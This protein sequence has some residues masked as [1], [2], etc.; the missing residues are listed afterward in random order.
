[1]SFICY[2]GAFL[3]QS[4]PGLVASNRGY[5]WGDGVFETLKVYKGNI[6]LGSFH[7]ERLL[8]SVQL[9]QMEITYTTQQLTA[10]ILELCKKNGCLNL[11]RVRLTIYREEGN[12]T[13]YTI[14]AIA[15]PEESMQ[16]NSRG[17][18]VDSY[19]YARKACD[20]FA[21]LKTSN[22]L[23]YV[24]AGLYAKEKGLDEVL[25]L[26]S[27]NHFC[28]ASKANIFWI[29][30]QEI[31]TPALDQGC[32]NGVMRRYIIERSK[33]IGWRVHQTV[34]TEKLLIEA[35][36]CFLTN[37]IQGMRWVGQYCE[38]HYKSDLTKEIFAALF[39]TNTY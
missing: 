31:F 39:P 7:F 16:W 25:V 34:L 27:Y 13:G 9:L 24:M 35:D 32:I 30:N 12:Q 37:A 3:Q 28:D 6:L 26:N 2:N 18:T 36:E 1:M 10:A 33:Q 4:Q 15:L 23:P 38:Q 8:L 29:K 14:E 20:V 5:K 21:N 11:A 22:Y 19:P 17:Y